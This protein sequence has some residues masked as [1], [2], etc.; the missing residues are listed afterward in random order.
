M[1]NRMFEIE[2]LES[3]FEMEVIVLRRVVQ[4]FPRDI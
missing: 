4:T 1:S 3:R 2:G